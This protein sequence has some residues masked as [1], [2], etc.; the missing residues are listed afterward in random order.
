MEIYIYIDWDNCEVLNKQKYDEVIG[1]QIKK[2]KNKSEIFEDYL[3]RDYS[4]ENIFNFTDE[5]KNEVLEKYEKYLEEMACEDLNI[6]K[7]SLD[8]LELT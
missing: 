4:L 5:D 7:F 2:L 1:N 8:D 6:E 3:S